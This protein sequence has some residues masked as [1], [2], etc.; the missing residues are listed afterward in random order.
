MNMSREQ[1]EDSPSRESSISKQARLDLTLQK[2]KQKRSGGH[3][4]DLAETI[5]RPIPMPI[6][7]MDSHRK[8]AIQSKL[9]SQDQHSLGGD[10]GFP[11][12]GVPVAEM[13]EHFKKHIEKEEEEANR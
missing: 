1:R 5:T 11:P 8:F 3:R 12:Q 7:L 4:G 2:I 13:L 9:S 6:P 10:L